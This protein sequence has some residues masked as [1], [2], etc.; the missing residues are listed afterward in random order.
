M[1]EHHIEHV[2]KKIRRGIGVLKRL[3][4][5]IPRGSAL[6]L[7]KTLIEP[8][9]RY[10][11]TVWGY[12]NETLKEKFQIL[13]KRAARVVT[14]SKSGPTNHD[15]LLQGLNWL[16]IHQMIKYDTAVLMYKVH[17]NIVS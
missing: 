13:Q 6:S 17:N 8:H 15:E 14:F 4:N 3:R 10:C 11:N 1:R 7:H 9:F 12:C 2:S 5:V 16:N